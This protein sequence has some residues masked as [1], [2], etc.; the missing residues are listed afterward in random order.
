MGA[1]LL[2][3]LLLLSPREILIRGRDYFGPVKVSSFLLDSNRVLLLDVDGDHKADTV[4]AEFRQVEWCLRVRA[5]RSEV[6]LDLVDAEKL[7][8]T[9]EGDFYAEIATAYLTSEEKPVLL[10]AVEGFPALGNRFWVYDIFNTARGLRAETLL[11]EPSAGWANSPVFLKPGY[12]EIKHFRN[13]TIAKFVWD[14]E[15]FVDMTPK[16]E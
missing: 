11:A 7:M 4:S 9:S 16:E 12:I 2:T 10:V 15:R 3:L 1:T 14:G 13:W 6:L 5:H 8:E